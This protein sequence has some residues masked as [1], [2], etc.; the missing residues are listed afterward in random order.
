MKGIN[1]LFEKVKSSAVREVQKRSLVSELIKKEVGQEVPIENISFKEGVLFIKTSSIIK[2]QIFIKKN[3]LIS[4][5]SK[6]I[7]ITDIR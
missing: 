4:L 5:V 7:N 6:K 1:H 2:N 3:K